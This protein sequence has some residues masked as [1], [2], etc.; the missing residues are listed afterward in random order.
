MSGGDART[1]AVEL[2]RLDPVGADRDALTDFLSSEEF[3]F[4]DRATGET[5]PVPWD[6]DVLPRG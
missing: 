2:V 5:T 6:E 3:P 4:H 1:T